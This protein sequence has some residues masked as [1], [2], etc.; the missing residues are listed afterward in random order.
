MKLMYLLG[1]TSSAVSW[2]AVEDGIE[3]VLGLGSTIL[4]AIFGNPIFV[5]LFAIG[6]VGVGFKIVHM[7]KRS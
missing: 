6:F 2:D 3:N 1:S 7:L 5:T 4:E